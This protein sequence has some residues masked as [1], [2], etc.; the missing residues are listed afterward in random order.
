MEIKLKKPD[1]VSQKKWNK[2][3]R[4]SK[5]AMLAML[6]NTSYGKWQA[7]QPFVKIEKKEVPDGWK[8]CEWCGK[9]FKPYQGRRFCE[10]ACRT[11]SYYLRKQEQ[12]ERRKAYMR[13]YRERKV[14]EDGK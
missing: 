11:S 10:E 14:V 5:K 9:P 8:R 4:L 12:R 6:E 7:K 2:M 1:G 3:D 13:D